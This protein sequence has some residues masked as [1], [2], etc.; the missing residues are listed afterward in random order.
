MNKVVVVDACLALK[1]VLPENDTDVATMLLDT[2]ANE[3]IEV[4]APDLFAYEVTNIL[5]RRTRAKEKRLTY[6]EAYSGL[7]KLF[8]IGISLR[9]S[10]EVSKDAMKL[11]DRYQLAATYDAHYLA[12]ASREGCEFWTADARLWRVVKADLSWVRCLEEYSAADVQ[13]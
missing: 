9:F 10:E 8:A 11:A 5:Y 2:W 13:S 6:S 4:V 3:G 1:W 7:E 12:L